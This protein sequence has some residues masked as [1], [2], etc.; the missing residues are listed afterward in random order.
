MTDTVDPNSVIPAGDFGIDPAHVTEEV[1]QIIA[2]N[3]SLGEI[4]NIWRISGGYINWS[5]GCQTSN[6]QGPVQYF[7]RKYNRGI[8]SETVRFEH[9]L[10]DHLLMKEY[11]LV[12]PVLR[13][14]EG[15]SFVTITQDGVERHIA[16]YGF[17]PGESKY[18]WCFDTDVTEKEL[19]SC[20]RTLASYHGCISDYCPTIERQS[21]PLAYQGCGVVPPIM[22]QLPHLP[23][24]YKKLAAR[25]PINVF[26]DYLH[27]K[28]DV[29]LAALQAAAIPAHQRVDLPMLV[30]H[31]DFHAGNVK[32]VD[33]DVVALF[34]FD[35]ARYDQ[36]MFDIGHAL[37]FFCFSWDEDS[38]GE[39]WADKLSIFLRTYQATMREI[40][41]VGPLSRH[42]LDYLIPYL[43]AGNFFTLDWDVR[44]YFAA[45]GRE[46]EEYLT[47][48]RHNV[49]LLETINNNQEL[50]MRLAADAAG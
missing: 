44:D 17:L 27:N 18:S 31:S 37:H 42:E 5:F 46:P 49:R 3:Y 8:G 2:T 19:I 32:Y 39:L 9:A 47:Y 1:R 26:G 20:A 48:L 22:D 6:D 21:D 30:V 12:A 16:V 28:I 29:I 11:S 33:G 14:L 15:K 36:R 24:V 43:H 45:P 34:D 23:A 50:I 13:T 25:A 7:I 41:G 10:V 38:N 4:T 35:Y 40:G